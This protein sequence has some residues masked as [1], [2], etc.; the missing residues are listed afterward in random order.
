M[1]PSVH[2]QWIQH[3]SKPSQVAIGAAANYSQSVQHPQ[4]SPQSSYP[5]TPPKEDIRASCDNDSTFT[6][7]SSSGYTYTDYQAGGGVFK[8]S[9]STSSLSSSTSPPNKSSKARSRTG[10]GKNLILSSLPAT[11]VNWSMRLVPHKSSYIV[12]RALAYKHLLVALCGRRLWFIENWPNQ[13]TFGYSNKARLQFKTHIWPEPFIDVINAVIGD[14]P[15]TDCLHWPPLS[16]HAC[17]LFY[18]AHPC[19]YSELLS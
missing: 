18:Q 17:L 6:P 2:N 4:Q 10:T 16:T 1:M 9:T 19:S 12:P 7:T 5:P 15:I 3:L 11:L 14:C 8:H 13:K